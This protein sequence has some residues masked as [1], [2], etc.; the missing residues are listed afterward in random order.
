MGDGG[1]ISTNDDDLAAWLRQ[2]R[3]MGIDKSTHARNQGGYSNDYAIRELGQKYHMNDVTAAI[4][5]A[6]LP[7][8][9][10]QI[11]ARRRIARAYRQALPLHAPSYSPE[12]SACHFYP[13]FF[14]DRAAVERR[15]QAAEIGFSRH[16][17]PNFLF[18]DFR[19]YPTPGFESAMWYWE[20]VLILPMFPGMTSEECGRI[21]EAVKG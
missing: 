1:G 19:G 4:G 17:Q 2:Q 18:P 13:M 5:L 8:V 12:V 9:A 14:E 10:N 20:H 16:Y 7:L 11:D 15:L 6:A 21:I 3:W